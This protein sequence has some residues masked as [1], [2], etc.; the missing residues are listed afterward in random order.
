[1]KAIQFL[2]VALLLVF[3][4]NFSVQ[5]Q[6]V[7]DDEKASCDNYKASDAQL[8]KLYQ[9]ILVEYRKDK[10]FI[11]KFRIAQ[12]AWLAFRDAHLDSLY[13]EPDARSA[14]GSVNVMCRCEAM[15]DLT[16]ARIKQLKKWVDHAEEGDVCSG[17]IKIK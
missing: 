13:P 10:L 15:N 2:F 3:A 6:A 17:S 1:M 8:N 7:G 4:F 12:R 16:Q 5:A 11:T 14:Y 9:R